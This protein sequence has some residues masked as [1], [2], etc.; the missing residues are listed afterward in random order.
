MRKREE[1]IRIRIVKQ[2]VQ[3]STQPEKNRR[4]ILRLTIVFQASGSFQELP[5]C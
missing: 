1:F 5:G 4:I 3:E 2:D